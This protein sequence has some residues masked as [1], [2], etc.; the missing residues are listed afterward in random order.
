MAAY[1]ASVGHAQSELFD[2][3]YGNKQ[4]GLAQLATHPDYFRRGA[5][6]MLAKWG[7]GLAE[8]N[9]WAITV[10]AGP[11]AYGPYERL[12]FKTLGIA[13]TQAKDEEEKIEFP[14]M[15]WEPSNLI[16]EK[17]GRSL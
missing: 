15:V 5:G 2:S 14:G 9:K 11:M 12:G 7:M 13:T 10:F 3:V 16:K 8:K 4:L 6:T 17:I 1:R